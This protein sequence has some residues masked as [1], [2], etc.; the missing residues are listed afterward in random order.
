MHTPVSSR[1]V[2]ACPIFKVEEA[3]VRLPSG[4]VAKRWHVVM[5]GWVGVL[6]LRDGRLVLLREYRSASQSVDWGIVAGQVEEG[7]TP[8]AAAIRE[9]R[10]EIGWEPLDL[11]LLTTFRHASP[12]IKMTRCLFLATQFREV[13]SLRR[14]SRCTSS[15]RLRWKHCWTASSLPRRSRC[16]GRCESWRGNRPNPKVF[17]SIRAARS[18]VPSP[19]GVPSE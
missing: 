4:S 5:L 8:E 10:Q 1:I 19:Q 13:A 16:T 9:V 18:V 15:R 11:R 2:F 6:C 3:D 14:A 17:T 12:F 7:E